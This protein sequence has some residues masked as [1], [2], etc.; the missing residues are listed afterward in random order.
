MKQDKIPWIKCRD[1]TDE[2]YRAAPGVNKSTL[3]ELI[4]RSPAHYKYALDNPTK[5]SPALA[6]G[7]ALHMAILQPN[8]FERHYAI[9]PDVDR[10]TKQGRKE[11]Q[12]FL[13]TLHG[14]EPISRECWDQVVSMYNAVYA[15]RDAAELLDGCQTE[16]PIFWTDPL[17]RV[18]CKCRLDAVKPG[19]IVDLKTA[20]D[21]SPKA[22]KSAAIR[23]GYE[24]QAAHYIRG[25]KSQHDEPVEFYFLVIE[26]EPPYAINIAHAPAAFVDR[27]TLTLIDALNKLK[28]CRQHRHWGGYG[29]TEINLEEWELIPDDIE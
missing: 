3:W 24:V 8:E 17:S 5:D 6:F 26:K 11:Y 20:A 9:A 28:E 16:T 12:A 10:R 22:F 23:F 7:R 21:A 14:R 27:G 19:V 4:K 2:Q 29:K 25:Y 18:R 13:D 15:D 1:M